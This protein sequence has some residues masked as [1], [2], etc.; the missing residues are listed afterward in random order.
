MAAVVFR[1][2]WAITK[3]RKK[4]DLALDAVNIVSIIRIEVNDLERN[5]DSGSAMDSFMNGAI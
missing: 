4:G 3:L 2:V 1:D 5:Y